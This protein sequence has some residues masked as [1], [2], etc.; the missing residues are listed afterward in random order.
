MVAEELARVAAK[1]NEDAELSNFY[2]D[3]AGGLES[4][5]KSSVNIYKVARA[6]RRARVYKKPLS[7]VAHTALP[8]HRVLCSLSGEAVAPF[9]FGE[10]LW[11]DDLVRRTWP[12]RK[13]PFV[14]FPFQRH[15]EDAGGYDCLF[16]VS[17]WNNNF[18]Q[19]LSHS[20]EPSLAILSLS[21]ESC[22]HM[23]LRTVRS[24]QQGELLSLD[25]RVFSRF[26]AGYRKRVCLC[27]SPGCDHLLGSDAVFYKPFRTE[28]PLSVH[29]LLLNTAL[30]VR[31]ASKGLNN[32]EKI[33]LGKHSLKRCVLEASPIWV[34]KFLGQLVVSFDAYTQKNLFLFASERVAE[35]G[36]RVRENSIPHTEPLSSEKRFRKLRCMA[37][38]VD[39]VK[40]FLNVRGQFFDLHPV[41]VLSEEEVLQ[42]V[43]LDNDSWLR[44]VFRGLE[45]RVLLFP[46]AEPDSI[47]N[48]SDFFGVLFCNMVTKMRSFAEKTVPKNGSELRSW[49]ITFARHVQKENKKVVQ[50]NGKEVLRSIIGEAF[51]FVLFSQLLFLL[52]STSC[53]FELNSYLPV[54]RRP[55][56]L[57][58]VVHP[59]DLA[60][61]KS[62]NK[63]IYKKLKHA[64]SSEQNYSSDFVW[65]SCLFWQKPFF[66]SFHSEQKRSLICP[67]TVPSFENCFIAKETPPIISINGGDFTKIFKEQNY[68]INE[69]IG[70][71]MGCPWLDLYINRDLKTY[72][73]T[74]CNLNNLKAGLI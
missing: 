6:L 46:E 44:K 42:K 65:T 27:T 29:K 57:Q 1:T 30:L 48:S 70:D 18:L 68:I 21:A 8:A 59:S 10:Q 28:R 31:S 26:F 52:G 72:Y 19:T 9:H 13:H 56:S 17:D 64:L 32:G 5:A 62:E 50:N 51:N 39:C 41:H 22:Y 53:F 35:S 34:K 2:S 43:W 16:F 12:H 54:C 63:N 15:F 37:V 67:L 71:L 38:F 24:V 33:A 14:A 40:H 45:K 66:A 4:V 49:L 11:A 25:H 3:P 69:K 73:N 61:L 74:C 55:L 60:V 20:C 23:C 58:E 47:D 7:V 36:R